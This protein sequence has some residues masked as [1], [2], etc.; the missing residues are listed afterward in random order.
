MPTKEDINYSILPLHMQEGMRLYLEKG[1]PTGDFLHHILSNNFVA[2]GYH[3]DETNQKCLWNYCKFLYNE[4]PKE[5][6]GKEETVWTWMKHHGFF[7]LEVKEGV[8][9]SVGY[10][11]DGDVGGMVTDNFPML[12]KCF[13]YVPIMKS[14]IDD[15]EFTFCIFRHE[16]EG[17]EPIYHWTNK[18]WFPG[19]PVKE[20]EKSQ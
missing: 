8:E 10:W 13:L 18:S 6:W 4:V 11:I 17:T 7:G 2:A 12:K 3:A 19:P 20:E 15:E 1:I 9:Y 14:I 16:P 5:A